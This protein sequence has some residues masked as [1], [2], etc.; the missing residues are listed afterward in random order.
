MKIY[1]P[2][3]LHEYEQGSH[4]INNKKQIEVERDEIV[5]AKQGNKFIPK[6]DF[7]GGKLHSEGGEPYLATEGDIIYPSKMRSEVKEAIKEGDHKELE[8]LRKKLP[9]DKPR[10]KMKQGGKVYADGTDSIYPIATKNISYLPSSYTPTPLKKVNSVKSNTSKKNS[11]STF[12][13]DNLTNSLGTLTEVAPI[14]YNIGQGLFGKTIK[15]TRRNFNPQ[16]YQYQDLSQPL[17]NEANSMYTQDKQSIR[18]ASGGNAGTYLSNVGLASANKFKRL[19]EIN[20][21]EAQRKIQ[22]RNANTDLSNNAQLN[23]NQ[24]NDQYDQLDLQKSSRKQDFLAAGLGQASQ[25]AQSSIIDNNMKKRDNTILN[26]LSSENYKINPDT[27]KVEK[28][29]NGTSGI[30]LKYKMKKC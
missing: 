1:Y 27:Y 12:N 2:E 26:N 24:L 13:T 22:T 21:T 7:K 25:F 6:A 11:K 5:M 28:K 8:N 17:R 18:N 3:K 19:Q 15:T 20:N 16:Q 10:Y 30:K 14:A 4:S 29:K 23:N 9:S